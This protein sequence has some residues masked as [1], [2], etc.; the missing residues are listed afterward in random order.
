LVFVFCCSFLVTDHFPF[1]EAAGQPFHYSFLGFFRL[2]VRLFLNSLGLQSSST[3]VSNFT[4]TR[5]A[6]DCFQPV[7]SYFSK[8]PVAVYL[9]YQRHSKSRNHHSSICSLGSFGQYTMRKFYP[10]L[11]TDCI[12]QRYG[13]DSMTV[14]SAYSAVFLIKV[15]IFMPPRFEGK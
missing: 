5:L 8:S 10:H 15:W 13:Q 3:P 4:C 1:F 6:T 14:M 9:L 11:F 7:G 2:H 12:I